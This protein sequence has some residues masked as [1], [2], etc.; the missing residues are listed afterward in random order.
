[1]IMKKALLLLSACAF[2]CLSGCSLTGGR[3]VNR[4]YFAEKIDDLPQHNYIKAKSVVEVKTKDNN[5]SSTIKIT[6]YWVYFSNETWRLDPD[7]VQGQ[8]LNINAAGVS[9]HSVV[10][11]S[12]YLVEDI[13]VHYYISP[14][15]IT[16]DYKRTTPS[17]TGQSNKVEYSEKYEFNKY[18]LLTKVDI[19]STINEE[20]NSGKYQ[21]TESLSG[22]VSYS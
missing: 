19:K 10:Q 6:N 3:E 5:S 12:Y 7:K 8:T 17:E 9:V 20:R 14:F 1:M 21:S 15:K 11:N 13:S 16:Y 22:K 2:L 4:D 18:G